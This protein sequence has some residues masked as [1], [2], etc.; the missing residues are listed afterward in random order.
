MT[1]PGRVSPAAIKAAA[2][3][4]QHHPNAFANKRYTVVIDY[5]LPSRVPRFLLIN[6]ENGSQ[7]HL[8]VAH[9]K[10]SDPDHDGNATIFSNTPGSLMTSLGTFSTRNTYYGRH[11]LSLR[12]EGLDPSND[13]AMERAIVI[14][15]ADYVA[16]GRSVIGR[17]WGCPALAPEITASVIDRIKDGAMVFAFHGDHTAT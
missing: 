12:L 6:T 13:A 16:P 1:A 15:G 9:G 10:G 4:F 11:G 5:S 14:H 17:S 8:L 7:E 3:R 2:A